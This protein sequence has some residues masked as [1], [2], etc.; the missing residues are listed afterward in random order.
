MRLARRTLAAS[1][2]VAFLAAACG[3]ANKPAPSGAVAHSA[4]IEALAAEFQAAQKAGDAGRLKA[5]GASVLPSTADLKGVLRA[6]PD[7]DAFLEAYK[8]KDLAGDGKSPEAMGRAL[9][10]PGKPERTETR[11]Y[12]AT[13]EEIAAYEK[14]G[15]PY[16][17]FPQSMKRFA[18]KVAAPGRVWWVV[19]HVVPGEDTGMKYSC[20]TLLGDRWLFL[21][22]PWDA[23]PRDPE[24][25][26]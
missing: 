2:V 21:A 8:A 22:K 13:T 19:E 20:F 25:D 4:N 14:G 10:A 24:D 9:F 26:K 12:A 6:G 11:A 23:I 1:V 7:T 5:L 17:E 15:V 3:E 16:A 18:R